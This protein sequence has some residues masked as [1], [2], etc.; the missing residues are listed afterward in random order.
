M[1]RI[2]IYNYADL[3]PDPGPNFSPFGPGSGCR[4]GSRGVGLKTNKYLTFKFFITKFNSGLP[5][6][7]IFDISIPTRP[8]PA[9]HH[10]PPTTTT[11]PRP[12]PRMRPRPPTT[13]PPRPPTTTGT[14]P[15]PPTKTTPLTRIRSL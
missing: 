14:R 3:D 6:P 2:R 10:P 1:L 7:L 9:T 11:R 5:E 8:R 4:S 13:T 15:R 12:S